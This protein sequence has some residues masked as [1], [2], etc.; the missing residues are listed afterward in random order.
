MH[1]AGSLHVY[2]PFYK[3]SKDI[4]MEDLDRPPPMKPFTLDG[5]DVLCTR[6]EPEIRSGCGWPSGTFYLNN[7]AETWMVDQL[8]QHR[9][10]RD[11][12]KIE[13]ARK[14]AALDELTRLTEEAGL[15]ETPKDWSPSE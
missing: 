13:H 6:H 15:Y 12:E 5:I 10:K 3:M 8:R 1:T 4:A 9:L 7:E 11:A 14:S 2:E